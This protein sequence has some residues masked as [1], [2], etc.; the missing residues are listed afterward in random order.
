LITNANKNRT[1]QKIASIEL[2]FFKKKNIRTNIKQKIKFVD[3][4]NKYIIGL[5]RL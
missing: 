4:D 3:S 2:I 5:L 1:I